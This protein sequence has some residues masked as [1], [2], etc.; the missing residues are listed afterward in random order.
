MEGL[1]GLL[2]DTGQ[3]IQQMLVSYVPGSQQQSQRGEE[4]LHIEAGPRQ[5]EIQPKPDRVGDQF[6]GL[7]GERWVALQSRELS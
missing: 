1:P 2:L 7:L 4:P 5:E 6:I 3:R